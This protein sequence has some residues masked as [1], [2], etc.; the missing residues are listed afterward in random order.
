MTNLI[1]DNRK[2]VWAGVT[3]QFEKGLTAEQAVDALGM[4][5]PIK[6][7]PLYGIDEDGTTYETK[8]Y[9]LVSP[10][11][12]TMFGVV[13]PNYSFLNNLEVA[14]VLDSSGL[15]QQYPV[16]A[17]GQ[18]PEGAGIVFVLQGKDT[19]VGKDKVKQYFLIAEGRT[20]GTAYRQAFTPVRVHCFNTL[21][22][23]WRQALQIMSIRHDRQFEQGLQM[24]TNFARVAMEQQK[25]TMATFE[26]MAT[27]KLGTEGL[28][29]YLAEAYPMPDRVAQR[30]DLVQSM[31]LMSDPLVAQRLDHLNQSYDYYK[32]QAENKRSFAEQLFNTWDADDP[33]LKGTL[34]AA[35]NA[36]VEAEDF[37]YNKGGAKGIAE[38]ATFGTRAATKV[39]ALEAATS[40]LLSR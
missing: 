40:L 13:G 28:A 14:Q 5:E 31:D 33:S 29:Q 23:A 6:K 8:K 15:T 20:G 27:F 39:L 37:G 18:T 19:R 9:G 1:L 25:R 32:R 38:S 12:G 2:P 10:N 35:Y 11:R 34:W 4:D 3:T 7:V 36:V 24:S 26:G 16:V 21:T 22:S 30:R 17:A